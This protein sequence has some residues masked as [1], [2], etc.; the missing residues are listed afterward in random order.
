[1]TLFDLTGKAALV[2]VA[3]V[4]DADDATPLHGTF[5]GFASDLLGMDVHVSVTSVAPGQ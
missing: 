1:M 3:V 2:T 5:I 4:S